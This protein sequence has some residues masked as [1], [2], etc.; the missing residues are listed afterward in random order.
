[1]L[2]PAKSY[3]QKDKNEIDHFIVLENLLKNDKLAIVATDSL[4][5]PLEHINGTFEFSLNGFNYPLAFRDGVA[6]TPNKVEK[7]T[8]LFI[9]HLNEKGSHGQLFYILKKESGLNPIKISW[10]FL[11]LIPLA[12]IMII[13]LFR[14]SLIIG[15]IVLL[16]FLYFNN[17]QGL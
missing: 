1:F 15:G 12:I 7:S 13:M 14:R 11:I 4:D 6:I 5:N 8:L 3:A 17:K 2:I 10:L 9:K 16:L